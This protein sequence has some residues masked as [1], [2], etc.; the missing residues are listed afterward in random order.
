[1]RRGNSVKRADTGRCAPRSTGPAA[2]LSR[3]WGS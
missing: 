1:L 3:R 2:P